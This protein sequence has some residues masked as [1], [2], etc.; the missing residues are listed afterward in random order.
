MSLTGRITKDDQRQPASIRILELSKSYS[1]TVAVAGIDLSISGG[2]FCTILGPSGSGKTTTLMMIAG[3]VTPTR[4]A[5]FIDDDDITRLA[6]QK[7]KLGIVF[8]N[9]ALFPH[10]N[11]YNNITFPLVMRRLSKPEIRIRIEKIL[12][13]VEL[14]GLEERLPMQLSGGQQQRVAVARAL[15]FEPRVL[16]MD[17]PLGA[18]DKKLRNS[19]Q[20]ELKRLQRRLNV[21]VIYVTHDQ[22]EALTISDKVVVM[23]D[24][25]IEQVGSPELLYEK[26]ATRFVADFIGDSNFIPGVVI[27]VDGE[28]ARIEHP[29]G[30]SVLGMIGGQLKSG[31]RVD[32]AM[33][34]ERLNILPS[35]PEN[36]DESQNVMRGRVDEVV[37]LG[38]AI[39]Y[40]V[41]IGENKPALA[42]TLS[43]KQAASEN[44]YKEGD[45]VFVQWPVDKTWL[46]LNE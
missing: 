20:L 18:L 45:Q 8:Q 13:I 29:T 17:E 23:N 46:L 4:G 37:Y 6:P 33:R 43:I 14:E 44:I 28:R 22:E 27:S 35:A 2:E 7:R 3:F 19:L 26:P 40:R 38:E 32:A 5:I 31:D 16:L 41:V 1:D 39:K 12:K 9:Y 11:V 34:P 42:H 10:M 30:T 25:H 36:S 21:T 24:G 15:V